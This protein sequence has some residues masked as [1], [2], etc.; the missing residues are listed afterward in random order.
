MAEEGNGGRGDSSVSCKYIPKR[1]LGN[2]GTFILLKVN[3]N[4]LNAFKPT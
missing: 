1:M 3:L 2:V 4:Q